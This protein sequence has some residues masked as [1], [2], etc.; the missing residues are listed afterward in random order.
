MKLYSK[1]GCWMKVFSIILGI[2]LV[3]GALALVVLG[4]ATRHTNLLGW[5]LAFLGVGFGLGGGIV[6][7]LERRRR[8]IREEKGDR[9][10]WAIIPGFL[11]IFYAPPIEYLLLPA[12]IPRLPV[13]QYASLALLFLAFT[14]RMWVRAA[15]GKM[16]T[17]HVQ[18]L[19]GHRLVR[20]G[21]YRWIRHPGYLGFV[22]MALGL[23]IGYSSLIGLIAI[24]TLMLPGLAYRINVEEKLLLAQFGD[25]Y[26]EYARHTRRLIPGLW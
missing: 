3:V 13:M 14:L 4:L 8:S 22:I 15:I 18:V 17:G 10:F 26:L 11:A 20:S 19:E 12:F 24:P 25:E 7:L 5:L 6:L 23:A 1:P 16:Y 2:L 21:P 9:S